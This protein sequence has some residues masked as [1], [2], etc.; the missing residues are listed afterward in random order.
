MKT[1]PL[2]SLSIQ[3]AMQMQF[4][5]VDAMT[6]HFHGDAVLNMGDLGVKAE[7][8]C[9]LTTVAAERVLKYFFGSEAVMLVRGAGTGAL[10]LA[11]FAVAGHGGTVLVH[12]A[13]MYP[14]TKTS[15]DMLG[16]STKVVDFHDLKAV[17]QAVMKE[18]PQAVLIQVT[19]QKPEDSYELKDVIAAIRIENPDIPIVTDDNYSAMKTP[20]IGTQLG[21]TLAT[22]S[23]FKLLGPEGVGVIVGKQKWIEKLRR[24]NYSGGLQVQGHEALEVLRGMVYAP[25]AL[26]ISAVVT[27]EV[28]SRLTQGELAGVKEAFVANAQSKVIIIRLEKPIAKAI[29]SEANRLGAAPHPVGAES[30]YETLPMFYR[31]S[32]TF[33]A[34]DPE[35]EHY[36][37]RINPMRAG[38]DTVIRIL[39]QS[40][41]AVLRDE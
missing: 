29:V 15:M 7:F 2:K 12:D 28:V 9:P 23:A 22:F 5:L 16:I 31:V 26:A 25:V 1:S 8:N 40:L 10:R 33:R 34:S 3:E 13:P 4:R 24:E 21:G 39:R 27:Q 14:T 36:M 32:G 41:E 17:R 19:R 11:L 35:A 20:Y 37:I 30:K 18:Q 38:A 6:R